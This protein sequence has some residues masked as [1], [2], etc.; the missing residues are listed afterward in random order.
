M[1]PNMTWEIQDISSDTL[2]LLAIDGLGGL[3]LQ[4]LV[5]A[6]GSFHEV[7]NDLLQGKLDD[8]LPSGAASLL[9]KRM[10]RINSSALRMSGES[11]NAK[12]LTAVDCDFPP[13]LLPL[14]AC[15][16]ILWC[17]GDSSLLATAGV[18]IVGSRRCS[19]YGIRQAKLFTKEISQAGLTTFSGGARGIDGVA[20][21]AALQAGG[22]NVVVLGSGL[23]IPYPPEHASLFDQIVAEGGV[24]ISEF[25]CDYAPK[26]A[27]FPRRNRIVSGLSSVVLVVEAA[28]RSG[29]LITA[30]IAVEEHGR[31]VFV[32]PGRIGDAA[33]AGC[34]RVLEEGWVQLALEASV[35][36]IEAKSAHARLV[37]SNC[38][39]RL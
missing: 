22:K 26:P 39:V 27:N 30:R 8:A 6:G 21:R 16:A 33:S 20:H 23:R 13:L 4:T 31:E 14:P 36:I 29:A 1:V 28:N 18:G 7:G 9:R 2:S 19:E 3:T 35:V 32:I 15:P 10:E 37:R 25:P 11:A 24:V 34:L 5:D 17:K 38:E 12:V